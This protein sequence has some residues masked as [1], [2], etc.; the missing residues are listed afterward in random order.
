MGIC[1]FLTHCRTLRDTEAVLLVYHDEA[2]AL[3]FHLLLNQG[4]CADDNVDF[5]VGTAPVKFTLRFCA[6][7]AD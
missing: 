6:G 7:S 2:Q 1:P 5:A 3:E 4:M